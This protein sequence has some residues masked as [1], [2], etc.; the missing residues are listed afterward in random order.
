ME[1]NEYKVTDGMECIAYN[2]YNIWIKYKTWKPI[3]KIQCIERNTF[4]TM[5]RL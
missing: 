5:D 4:K 3:Y 1:Q 2:V